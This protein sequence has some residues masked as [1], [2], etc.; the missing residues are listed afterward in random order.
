MWHGLIG[1]DSQSS[2]FDI[3]FAGSAFRSA[4][5]I[6]RTNPFLVSF[7]RIKTFCSFQK[8]LGLPTRIFLQIRVIPVTVIKKKKEKRMF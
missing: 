8:Q 5:G 6:V 7:V 4:A 3:S 1:R 2:V